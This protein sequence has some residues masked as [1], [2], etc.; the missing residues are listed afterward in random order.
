MPQAG[1]GGQDLGAGR[2]VLLDRAPLAFVQR[3]RLGQH[4]ERDADLAQV[5]KV[6]TGPDRLDDPFAQAEGLAQ[7]GAQCRYPTRVSPRVRILGVDQRAHDLQELATGKRRDL[8]RHQLR[9]GLYA[10][11]IEGAVVEVRDPVFVLEPAIDPDHLGVEL[12]PGGLF[13]HLPYGARLERPTLGSYFPEG[14]NGVGQAYDPSPDGNVLTHQPVG[15]AA[16]VPPLVMVADQGSEPLEVG[17]ADHGR[18][19][20]LGML[21]HTGACLF[22][23]NWDRV[24]PR[25]LGQADHAQIREDGAEQ[26]LRSF[27]RRKPH[28]AADLLAHERHTGSVREE[29][30]LRGAHHLDERLQKTNIECSACRAS[31]GLQVYAACVSWRNI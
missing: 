22:R 16:S 3:A 6:A 26:Q 13:H 29:V 23:K 8:L 14:R 28:L 1:D 10:G 17:N 20:A 4:R 9:G 31:N 15:I 27:D 2:C 25:V 18:L 5:V 12:D 11:P 19:A 7:P 24:D 21:L 30:A